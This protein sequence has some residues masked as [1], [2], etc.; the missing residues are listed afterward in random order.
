MQTFFSA[1]LIA[2]AAGSA[3]IANIEPIRGSITY[4]DAEIQVDK[5]PAG[6]IFF[7]TFTDGE[8]RDVREIYRVNPDQTVTLVGRTLAD[9]Y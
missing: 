2:V 6:S 5:R 8:G 1:A 9:E 7:H 3:A 4:E